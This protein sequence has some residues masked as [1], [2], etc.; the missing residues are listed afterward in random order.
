MNGTHIH[1]TWHAQKYV[2]LYA[3]TLPHIRIEQAL[4]AFNTVSSPLW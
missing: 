3:F 2:F 1:A 4:N